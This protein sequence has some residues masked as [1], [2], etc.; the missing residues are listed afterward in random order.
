M[1]RLIAFGCSHTYGEGLKDCWKK[2][3]AGKSPSKY[4][5]PQLLA[6]RLKRKCCNKSKE[7]ASNKFIWHKILNTEFTDKDIVVILWTYYNRTCILENKDSSQ[8]IMVSDVDNPFKPEQERLF[9]KNYYENYYTDY[10]V[11]T[12]SIGYFNHIKSY[13]DN[14]KVKNYHLINKEPFA[15]HPIPEWNQVVLHPIDLR[16][17]LPLA[18]DNKHPGEQAHQSISDHVYSIIGQS[19]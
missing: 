4:A 9:A 11:V 17:D 3:K 7:G 12:H 16:F 8:R 6:E 1:N 18:E 5:W 15:R 14:L 13:L 19:K 10:D 2:G